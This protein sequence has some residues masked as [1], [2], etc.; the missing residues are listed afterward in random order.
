MGLDC[1]FHLDRDED[2]TE[3]VGLAFSWVGF[4]ELTQWATPLHGII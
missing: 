4:D 3:I 1:G 2:V